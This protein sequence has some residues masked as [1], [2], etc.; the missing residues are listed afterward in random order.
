MRIDGD[1]LVRLYEP[2]KE[3]HTARPALIFFHGGGMMY[4]NTEIYHVLTQHLAIELDAV[5]LSVGHRYSWQSPYPAALE[6]STKATVW[7]MHHIH[8]YNVDASRIAIIGDSAGG[9]LAAAVTQRL[10]FN[11]E[12]ADLPTLKFN[13]LLYPGLQAFDFLTPSF[14]QHGA[15]PSSIATKEFITFC[16]SYYV[17]GNDGLKEAFYY[18]THTSPE[19]KSIYSKFLSHDMIPQKFKQNG[20]EPP[21]NKTYGN[22]E[23]YRDI[24][25]IL[26]HP[27]AAPLLREDLK[28]LPST[29]IVTVEQ[30][31]LRDDGII[32]RQRLKDAGVSVTWKHYEKGIHGMFQLFIDPFSIEAGKQS[33]QDL[34]EYANY[35]F[36]R[37]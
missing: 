3:V 10:T 17:I 15:K 13:A 16:Y 27:D 18:N 11:E 5:L 33:V 29:Y 6:D 32:Y 23:I 7:F 21:K 30:D 36:Y 8:K 19:A 26:V 28:G 24:E 31:P 9:N 14:Q 22:E 20:Y 2:V 25:K 34:I 12:F 37:K 1:V 4:G 35:Q